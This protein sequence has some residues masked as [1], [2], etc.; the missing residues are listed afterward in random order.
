MRSLAVLLFVLG[1]CDLQPAPKQA[2]TTPATPVTTP[3]TPGTPVAIAPADAGVAPS[4]TDAAAAVPPPVDASEVSDRCVGVGTHVADIL[5]EE[6][7]DPATKAAYVQARS[8]TVRRTAE[9]C[10]RDAWSEALIGCYLASKT[11]A[12]MQACTKPATP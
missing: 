3:T 4:P 9:A 6:A 8:R 2:P 1:A 10:T 12:A 7:I 11:Q 5:I